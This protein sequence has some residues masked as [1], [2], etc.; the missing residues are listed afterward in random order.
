VR[1]DVRQLAIPRPASPFPIPHALLYTC[2]ECDRWFSSP[3]ALQQKYKSQPTL[4]CMSAM[5]VTGHF[6]AYKQSTSI[7]ILQLTN[8]ECDKCDDCN[9]CNEYDRSFGNKQALEQHTIS[10]AYIFECDECD[11]SFGSLGQLLNCP[12]YNAITTLEAGQP[13]QWQG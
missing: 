5:I 13:L 10:P 8:F 9:E 4:R 12:R 6:A 1:L 11:R 3:Q 2:D 7:L